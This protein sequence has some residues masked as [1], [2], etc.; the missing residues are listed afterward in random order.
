M[1]DAMPDA[2]HADRSRPILALNAGSSSL[3]FGLYLIGAGT[4]RMLVSGAADLRD[5]RHGAFALVDADGQ[6]LG[7][8]T[9]PV[10]G[11]DEAVARIAQLLDAH[12]LPAPLAVGH[13]IV[14]GGP[15]VRRHCLV[16]AQ[17]LRQ[18]ESAAVFA[19]LHVP[20]ALALLRCAQRCFPDIAHVAC[21]DTAFHA[22]MPDVARTLPLPRQLRERGIQ[23]YGFHGLSCESIVHQLR[24]GGAAGG[25]DVELPLPPRLVIAHLGHGASVTA[26][27][28]GRSIDTS[29]GLTPSGGVIMGTRC[30]D[31]DPG[32]L[33]HLAREY[34]YDAERLARLI[35]HESGLIAVSAISGDMRELRAAAASSAQAR[36]AIAM[37]CYSVRKQVAAMAAALGGIDLLVF[38]GGIGEHDA[39]VRASIGAGLAWLGIAADPVPMQRAGGLQRR[40][41]APDPA[42]RGGAMRVMQT[43]EEA[44]IAI[45]AARLTN[46]APS[47]VA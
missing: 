35:D 8:D 22:G 42:A 29:M 20:P 32:V 18:L 9:R 44:Q 5:G 17:V 6:A 16:D 38:T 36:L 45:H 33:V 11:P 30:G 26:V 4:Q 37:F 31:I 40:S 24:A 34:G 3:K 2:M 12:G 21:L 43:R 13:R 47:V 23:R 28:D 46:G 25:A 10:G 39:A 1:H 41:G 19:P 7:C 15:G 14:H 27:A